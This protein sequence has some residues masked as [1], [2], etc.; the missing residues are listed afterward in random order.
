MDWIDGFAEE[1]RLEPLSPHEVE[2]LLATSRDVA[3]LVERKATPLA[4]YL[5][6]LAVG[7]GISEG[8][9]RDDAIEE[10]VHSLLLRLPDGPQ[11]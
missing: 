7:R 4:M 3:H 1:L 5:V 8:R 6:G 9:T 2:H 11:T 10:A